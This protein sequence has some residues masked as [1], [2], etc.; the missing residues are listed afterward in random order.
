MTVII[1]RQATPE[2]QQASQHWALWES[3]E[4]DRFAYQYDQDVQFVVQSGE[5]VI[6]SPGNPPVAI[7][8]GNHVTIRKGVDGLWAIRTPVVNRYQYL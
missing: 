5:A 3:G 7:A 2:E 4:T 6:H 1:K 8:A